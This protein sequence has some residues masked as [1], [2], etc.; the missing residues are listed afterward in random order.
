MKVIVPVKR[1]PDTA[2]EKNIDP[3]D[4]TVDRDGIESV[5]CPINEF[6]I[7]EAVRLKESAG[8][9][10]KVLLMGPESAQPIVRKALSYGLDGAV[11]ITDDALAGS[12][13]IGTAKAIAAALQNEEFDLVIFGNQATDAR[14]CVVPAAV[15]EILGL[16]SL[17]YAR[18]LEVDGDKVVVHREHEEGYDVVESTLPA[19]VS[20]VE[21]INEPRYPS[22][23]GIMAAK[24][25]PLE[26][27]SAADIG[28]DTSEVGQANAWAV[29]TEFEQRPPKEAG[30]IVEDDGSGSAATQL[31]DWMQAKK[32]V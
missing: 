17:T 2:G 10:V 16:P 13:A 25:K 18:H 27:K 8:A 28:L 15:A 1:V 9:E 4:K 3:N 30:T 12:D 6:S 19:V 31:A 24:S 11:Q 7:E 29:L 20:V 22:F 26:V 5:L 14:T 23:K 32:F 21:A